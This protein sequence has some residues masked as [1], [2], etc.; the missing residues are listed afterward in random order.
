MSDE[1]IETVTETNEVIGQEKRS[2]VHRSGQWH[3]GVHVFLFDNSGKLLVQQR[4]RKRAQFPST[5]DCSVSEHLKPNES[6]LDAAIRG[7]QE[8]LG[9]GPLHLR[10]LTQFRMTYGPG[11]NMISELYEG[12]VD[13]TIVTMDP[14]EIERIDHFT[15]TELVTLLENHEQAFS[16]WFDQLLRWYTGKPSALI[17]LGDHP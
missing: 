14:E 17:Q 7:M 15:V 3:R 12:T 9:I 13:P 5:F 10:R 16:P 4:S 1:I 2:I 11:D 6:Y 8:E